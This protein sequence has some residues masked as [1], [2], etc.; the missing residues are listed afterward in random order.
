MYTLLAAAITFVLTHFVAA[1]P[2]RTRLVAALGRG[3]YFALFSI[4]SLASIYWLASEFSTAPYGQKLWQM[5]AAWL[6]VKAALI[7]FAFYLVVAGFSTPS[8]TLPGAREM[9]ERHTLLNGVL[10]I[11]RHPLMWGIAIWA[12]AHIVSQATPRGLIFFGAF[13]VTALLGAWL[14]ERRKPQE[15]GSAWAWFES[16]TSFFPFVALLRGRAHL[17]FSALGWWRMALAVLLWAAMLHLH[18]WLF[19]VYPLPV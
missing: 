9:P 18:P 10:A 16:K 2:L 11:T 14:Q 8:P 1:T 4:V 7:L 3:V 13:A 5:P 19:G 12:T 6:W 15:L 17:S